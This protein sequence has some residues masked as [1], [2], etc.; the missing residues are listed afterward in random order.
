MQPAFSACKPLQRFR[1]RPALCASGRKAS[2]DPQRRHPK[3]PLARSLLAAAMPLLAL[4][5]AA[6]AWAAPTATSSGRPVPVAALPPRLAA[7]R[8]RRQRQTAAA[9]GA[10]DGQPHPEESERPQGDSKLQDSLVNQLQF[11]IG[12]KRV[13]TSRGAGRWRCLLPFLPACLSCGAVLLVLPAPR[14]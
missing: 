9:A 12:K 3:A 7:D 1:A 14:Q 4:V 6:C 10:G 8:R 13:R 2:G 11:E 5:P